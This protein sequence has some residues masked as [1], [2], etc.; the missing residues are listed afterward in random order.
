[1][2]SPAPTIANAVYNAIG[3]WITDMPITREK[4][5]AGLKSA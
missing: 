3:V 1:M 4:V 2:A 5:L